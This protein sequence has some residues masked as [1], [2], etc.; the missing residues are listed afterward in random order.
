MRVLVLGGTNFIGPQAVRA[1][2]ADGHEVAVFH[3]GRTQAELPD[4]V[5]HLLGDRAKLAEQAD[6]FRGFAPE[7][8]LDM[9]ACTEADGQRLTSVF[10]GLAQRVV[11]VSSADVYR[12]YDRL[13]GA[14]PG[15]PDPTPLTEDSPLRDRLYPYREMAKG[16]D[17]L[18]YHYEKILMERALR[19]EP[20]LPGTVIRLPMVYG[21]GDYQHRLAEYLRRMDAG[22]PAIVL[23]ASL[24]G[25]HGLRGYV[26]DI[27]RA[28]ALCVTEPAAADRIYH[29]ADADSLTEADWVRRIGRAAGWQGEVVIVPD[30]RLPEA[31]RPGMDC[32]QDWSID[33]GRI[34]AELGYTEPT[35]PD[36]AMARSVAWERANP[37]PVPA[38]AADRDAAE[39]QVLASL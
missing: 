16:P 2:S 33:S 39:D 22:R 3:R 10:R 11:A 20:E 14:D 5:T 1:L 25:W 15:P 28:I 21:S 6:A 30:E 37:A 29:V 34:R 17:E 19:A 36:E 31:L 35:P 4:G 13:R 32:A 9:M 27:G 7:L 12:A 23:A 26:E 8:V 38:D 18:Y 24:A